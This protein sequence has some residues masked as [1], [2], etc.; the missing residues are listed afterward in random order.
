MITLTNY[1]AN[2]AI[3]FAFTWHF[4]PPSP[5]PP[6]EML[7][8]VTVNTAIDPFIAMFVIDHYQR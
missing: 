4:L 7:N 8:A 6:P 2:C 1:R 3:V 5:P